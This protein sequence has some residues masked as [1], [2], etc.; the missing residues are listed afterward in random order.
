MA[1]AQTGWGIVASSGATVDHEG[2]QITP[3]PRN[4]DGGEPLPGIGP[5]LRRVEPKDRH[6]GGQGEREPD[7]SGNDRTRPGAESSH[8][9]RA[10]ARFD[11]DGVSGADD[12]RRLE[13][14]W[15]NVDDDSLLRRIADIAGARDGVEEHLTQWVGRARD[16]GISWAR[17]G[18]TLG[19]TRQSA[20]ERF[21]RDE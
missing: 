8:G 14:Q 18:A 12:P 13:P 17:I 4:V 3:D 5:S 20:W 9:E 1:D 10:L 16:R 11:A 21:R 2:S 19:M 7:D 15:Q 6:G